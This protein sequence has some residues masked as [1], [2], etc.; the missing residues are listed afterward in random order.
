MADDF[1]GGAEPE[2]PDSFGSEPA[3]PTVA[4]KGEAVLDAAVEKM[5]GPVT[6]EDDEYVPPKVPGQKSKAKK[7]P[8][9]DEAEDDDGDDVDEEDEEE[10]E[11]SD[12]DAEEGELEE[13][14]EEDEDGDDEADAEDEL[15]S[16]YATLLALPKAHRPLLSDL[17]NMPRA[18]LIAW[19]GRVD[20]AN[21]E[22]KEASS[23]TEQGRE[24]PNDAK[25]TGKPASTWAAVRAGLAEKLGIDEDAADALKPLHDANEALQARLA[26]LEARTVQRDGQVTIDKEMRRL[27]AQYGPILRRDSE[28]QEAILE[29]AST[30][31]A[32]LKARGV[33]V[34]ARKVFDQAARAVM[35][36]GPKADLAT[37]RRNG[38]S[39]PP[40]TIGNSKAAPLDE[41][42]YW[43]RGV[44]LALAGKGK[45][46]IARLKPPPLKPGRR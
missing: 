36:G 30:I 8:E 29:H 9:P 40:E 15:D 25:E 28:K 27:T 46:A 45:D 5:L 17:K 18:K 24:T 19:A 22:A 42:S 32:G 7:D 26:A 38:A 20:A 14:D 11:A 37:K 4:E 6:K 21:A 33:A 10:L 3:E 2:T 35:N 34:N 43:T 23:K 1:P 39:T 44:D 16:A 12:S 31:A 13:K 41:E